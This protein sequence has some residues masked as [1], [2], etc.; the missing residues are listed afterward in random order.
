M[1]AAALN[2]SGLLS[3][4]RAQ[5]EEQQPFL[6]AD[7]GS[8]ALLCPHPACQQDDMEDAL[9]ALQH[10]GAIRNFQLI[11]TPKADAFLVEVPAA[12]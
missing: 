11:R 8:V 1:Q 6:C 12:R 7:V 2:A 4:F 10:E 5:L 3:F 9:H